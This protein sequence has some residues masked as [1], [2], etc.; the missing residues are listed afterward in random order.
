MVILED[1]HWLISASWALVIRAR[2][3]IDNLLLM[4]TDSTDRRR[5]EG[6]DQRARRRRELLRVSG[7][8]T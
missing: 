8:L 4:I 2:R 1:A 3:E 5:C 7:L 6:P